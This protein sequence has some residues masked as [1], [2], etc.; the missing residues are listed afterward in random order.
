MK[1]SAYLQNF[2]L[3]GAKYA[4]RRAKCHPPRIALLVPLRRMPGNR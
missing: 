3:L 1:S 2:Y 4:S